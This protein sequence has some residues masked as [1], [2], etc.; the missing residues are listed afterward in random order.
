MAAVQP[1]TP[2]W[3]VYRLFNIHDLKLG[4][5]YWKAALAQV[6]KVCWRCG[7]RLWAYETRVANR[8]AGGR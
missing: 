3:E 8:P 2:F 5:I 7:K 4:G 6:P 1:G